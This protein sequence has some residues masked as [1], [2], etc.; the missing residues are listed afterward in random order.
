MVKPLT[1]KENKNGESFLKLGGE[2]K[3]DVSL[4]N[5]Q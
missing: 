5:K 2:K 4:S 1:N 3:L